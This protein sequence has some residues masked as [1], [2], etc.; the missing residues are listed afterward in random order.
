MNN[1]IERSMAKD[2]GGI[3]QIEVARLFHHPDNPRKDLGDVSELAESIKKNGVMQNLTIIPIGFYMPPEEQTSADKIGPESDFH[4]LIGNRR[5]EAARMAGV[6][7]VP[8]RIV[9]N[10]DKRQQLSIMLEENM[11]RSDLTILEQAEGFQMMLDLGDTVEGIKEKTG[12]S[13]T[14]IYH[15]LNIAKLDKE[16]LEEKERDEGFQLSVRVLSEL[17]KVEDVETRNEILKKSDNSRD[18][19]N[20]VHNAVAKA[21]RAENAKAIKDMLKKIGVKKATQKIENEMYSSKWKTVREFDLEKDV[22]KQLRMPKEE[23]QMY[24]L[25]WY[26]TLKVIIKAP[27]EKRELS[28]YEKEE[29]RKAGIKKQIR[30]ILKESSARRR[31]LVRNIIS[32]KIDAAEDEAGEMELVWRAMAFIGSGV[33]KSTIRRFFLDKDEYECTDEERR[34]AGKKA[35]S[36][37]LLHQ[38]L[39]ILDAAMAGTKETFTYNL[40]FSRE[41]G[42]ALMEG[43]KALE[44]YGWYFESEDEARVLD[45]TH[46]LYENKEEQAHHDA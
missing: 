32:G 35:E 15:R 8:C 26:R 27:K 42:H 9:S 41:K 3:V 43:Y 5:L 10:L 17:E 4:V 6:E 31:D 12:F 29:R 23:G 33:Y 14:T 7:E 30:E 46:E 16:T 34:E 24:Y 1:N 39:V 11:Q 36:L 22:P 18:V 21:K 38:M 13:K 45:G 44:P 37:C 25:L 20:R 28:P 19:I 40:E 2:D